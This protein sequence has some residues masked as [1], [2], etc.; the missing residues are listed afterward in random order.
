[1][2]VL[3]RVVKRSAENVLQLFFPPCC[4]LC[5]TPLS[6]DQLRARHLCG[7]CLD[8]FR[9]LQSP[10]CP[11][12]SLPYPAHNGSD[13]LCETCQ[14]EEPPFVWAASAGIFEGALRHAI[15]RFK[16][17]Q[18]LDLDRPLAALLHERTAERIEAFAPDLVVAVPL[19]SRRLRERTY[20][21][22]LL[23]ARRMAARLR[24]PCPISALQRCRDTTSQ[25]HLSRDERRRNLH[26]AFAAERIF[27]QRRVLLVDDVMTT[28]ATVSGCAAALL[29]A[30]ATQVA[31]VTLAR[32]AR[33]GVLPL[34]SDDQAGG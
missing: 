14:R 24:T 8:S 1:M 21:Q 23:L 20:N 18:R 11:R 32:A 5:A 31:V 33:M 6:G 27:Y 9:L 30:G 28:G 13:H 2:G 15:L 3:P 19:H 7:A 17:A 25:Q 29:R 34:E 22:A 12:C 26:S 16:F 4:P 10:C